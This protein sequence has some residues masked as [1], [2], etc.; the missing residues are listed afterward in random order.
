[1]ITMP[2]M[3]DMAMTE[4]EAED[5]YGSSAQ[6]KPENLPK[7]PYG[8]CLSFCQD[9]LDKLGLDIADVNVGDVIHLFALAKITSKSVNA[10]EAGDQSRLELQITHIASGDGENN[11]DQA[12][13][14]IKSLYGV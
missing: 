1:M 11:T 2:Q 12:P 6:V 5:K 8:L 10:T 13:N 3:V 14:P 7:Y 4:E 9:E